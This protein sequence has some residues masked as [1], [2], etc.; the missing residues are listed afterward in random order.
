MVFVYLTA[1]AEEVLEVHICKTENV[2]GTPVETKEMS[3]GSFL[4]IT[5]HLR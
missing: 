1:T 5:S 2:N 4:R 3:S